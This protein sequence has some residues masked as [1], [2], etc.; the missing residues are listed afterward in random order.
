MVNR[1]G[2]NFS[3]ILQQGELRARL[4]EPALLHSQERDG[5]RNARER[6]IDGETKEQKSGSIS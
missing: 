5:E 1:A 4:C 2:Q 6:G 3:G